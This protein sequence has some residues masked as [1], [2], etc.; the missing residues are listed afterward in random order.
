MW[1][2]G[3]LAEEDEIMTAEAEKLDTFPTAAGSQD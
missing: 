1:V 2:T 3:C